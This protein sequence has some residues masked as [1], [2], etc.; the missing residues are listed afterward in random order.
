MLDLIQEQC[1]AIQEQY[2]TIDLFTGDQG[3][4]GNGHTL[5]KDTATMLNFKQEQYWTIHLFT[6]DQGY[7][8]NGH[9]L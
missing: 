4:R 1:F 6:R 7:Q 9:A 3:Y 5:R 2:W 8:G